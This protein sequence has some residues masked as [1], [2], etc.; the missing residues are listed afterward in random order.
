MLDNF[1][2]MKGASQSPG[3]RPVAAIRE[4]NSVMPDG[5]FLVGSQ[6]PCVICQP[7]SS[8]KTSNGKSPRLLSVFKMIFS[9]IHLYRLYQEHH[10]R[11]GFS[12]LVFPNFSASKFA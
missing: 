10:T 11:G 9:L 4:A 2:T 8:W 5:N 7:S 3:V 1:V 6:S 12:Y